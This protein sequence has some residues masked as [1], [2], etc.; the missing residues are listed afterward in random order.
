MNVDAVKWHTHKQKCNVMTLDINV[1]GY[2]FMRPAWFWVEI[3]GWT[4][5]S[6]SEGKKNNVTRWQVQNRLAVIVYVVVEM[7]FTEDAVISTMS[8]TTTSKTCLLKACHD[9]VTPVTQQSRQ[10]TRGQ[11]SSP[12]CRRSN[13]CQRLPPPRNTEQVRR[14]E[15]KEKRTKG[16][17]REEVAGA[18]W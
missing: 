11:A 15:R 17:K 6:M 10:L 18:F 8:D 2:C 3:F 16:L 9:P 14:S 13:S 4:E 7:V 1:F 5:D 12:L